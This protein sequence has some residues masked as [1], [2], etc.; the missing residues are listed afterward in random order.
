M[1]T[2]ADRQSLDDSGLVR[3]LFAPCI[4]SPDR[5][6]ACKFSNLGRKPPNR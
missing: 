5:Y 2:G 1:A 3:P 6:K 4:L